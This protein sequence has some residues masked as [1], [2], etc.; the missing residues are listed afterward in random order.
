[1]EQPGFPVTVCPMNTQPQIN[2]TQFREIRH[3]FLN[4]AK[5]FLKSPE[6][7]GPISLKIKHSIRVEKEIEALAEG[8]GLNR[9]QMRLAKVTGL[10]HD[11]GRFEQY[12]RFKTFSDRDSVDHGGFGVQMI[13]NTGILS[14]IDKNL[15]S[16]IEY[17]VTNHNQLRLPDHTDETWQLY[18]KLIRDADKLDIFNIL[19]SEGDAGEKDKLAAVFNIKFP[20]SD[21]SPDVADAVL[22]HQTVEMA[23]VKSYFDLVLLRMAWVF[24]M[25]FT[26]TV[27]RFYQLEYLPAMRNYLPRTDSAEEL[28]NHILDFVVK[29]ATQTR[30]ERT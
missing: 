14:D 8:I 26:Q 24:D 10:L 19:C 16:L 15:Q 1:M 6:Q 5:K 18:A 30:P 3:Q 13:Q 25:N 21:I 12:E 23:S 7:R 29:T 28:Y 2:K 4:Y 22:D 9:N 17:A 27:Q 20:S 11:I